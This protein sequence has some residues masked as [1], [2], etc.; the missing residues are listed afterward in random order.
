[1]SDYLTAFLALLA[2]ASIA[3]FATDPHQFQGACMIELGPVK[4][5]N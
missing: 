4:I 5:C 3:S 1:M 2:I